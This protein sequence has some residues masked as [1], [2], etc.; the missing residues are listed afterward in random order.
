MLPQW[1]QQ[2]WYQFLWRASSSISDEDSEILAHV[3]NGVRAP[4]WRVA[5]GRATPYT[6]RHPPTLSLAPPQLLAPRPVFTPPTPL[7]PPAP[8]QNYC[9]L[10]GTGM[11][12][13][14]NANPPVNASNVASFAN[15]FVSFVQEK[16]APYQ[17]AA[18]QMV[19]WGCDFA[20]GYGNGSVLVR[21]CAPPPCVGALKAVSVQC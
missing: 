1:Q 12:W 8:L 16:K 6:R 7:R 21:A 9:D 4:A 18:P 10:W 2:L 11:N 15:T 3:I 14:F 20:F 19:V 13:E 17:P 5:R